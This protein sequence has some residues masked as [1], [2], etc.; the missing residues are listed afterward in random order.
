MPR[1]HGTGPIGRR[2]DLP[3]P[4]RLVALREVGDAFAHASAHAAEL[5]AGTFVFV[6]RFDIAEFAVVLEPEE[7]LASARRAFYAGMVALGDAL[8]ACAPPEKPITVDWPDAIH[9][10]GGLVGGGRLGWPDGAADGS[11]PDWLVFG[12][13]IRTA[14][15]READAGR[16]PFVTALVEEG[17]DDAAPE[18]IAERF[19]RHLMAATH[20]WQEAGFAPIAEQYLARLVPGG[21]AQREIAEN[22]D[23]VLRGPGKAIETRSLTTAL[24]NPSWLDRA[25]GLMRLGHSIVAAG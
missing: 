16:Y 17:F 10:D 24:R 23:L 19:A 6:G 14:W 11:V 22:G 8:A 12:A 5:G 18:R 1:A 2:L 3:P 9:V 7:P 15:P 4:F 25:S 20:L 13:M 21:D